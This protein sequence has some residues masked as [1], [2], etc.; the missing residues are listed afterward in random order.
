MSKETGN[1]KHKVRRTFI[2]TAI[3]TAVATIGGVIATAALATPMLLLSEICFAVAGVTA[4]V[5]T[6]VGIN[7]IHSARSTSSNRKASIKNLQKIA[8][9][10]LS[11]SKDAKIKIVKKFANANLKLCKLIGCP[12]C[13]KFHSVSGMDHNSKTEAFNELENLELLQSLETTDGGRKKWEPKI[14]QKRKLVASSCLRSVP[15]RWTKSY[16]DFIDGVS[17]YDRRTEIGCLSTKT[18]AEFEKLASVVPNT[19]EIGASV[20]LT[21][22]PTC[23]TQTTYARIADPTLVHDVSRLMLQDVYYACEGKSQQERDAMFPFVVRTHTIDKN[24]SK[25][26]DVTPRVIRSYDQLQSEL[27]ITTEQ[28]TT[29]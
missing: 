18:G 20:T 23:R 17:I 28:V 24:T 22:K 13:G 6:G 26:K 3:I 14:S 2:T 25:I 27:G 29:R 4:V 12:F 1:K 8:E 19:D 5:G 10:D 11:L 15:H 7:A 9:N 16:D 21:F